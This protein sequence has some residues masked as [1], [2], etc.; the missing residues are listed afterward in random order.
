MVHLFVAPAPY[1]GWGE[2]PYDGTNLSQLLAAFIVIVS[3][4]PLAV[5]L[6][7]CHLPSFWLA[8][9]TLTALERFSPGAIGAWLGA[10][11]DDGLTLSLMAL[12][13][14]SDGLKYAGAAFITLM[15]WSVS[16]RLGQ[17]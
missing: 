8:A 10:F 11:H 16:P 1:E 6:T 3:V 13:A 9:I 17:R 12:L 2:C 15:R 4:S 14:H 5:T 7:A